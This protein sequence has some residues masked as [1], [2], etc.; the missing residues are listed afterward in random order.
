MAEFNCSLYSYFEYIVEFFGYLYNYL[1]VIRELSYNT[2]FFLLSAPVPHCL[3]DVQLIPPCDRILLEMTYSDLYK[4]A[5]KEL[6]AA[7]MQ[8]DMKFKS[9]GIN[10]AIPPVDNSKVI[11]FTFKYISLKELVY[12]G[13]FDLVIVIVIDFRY[14]TKYSRIFN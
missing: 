11:M 4:W 3:S 13:G 14:G 10:P 6:R 8:S 5:I 2:S 1:S 9:R 12:L 7:I